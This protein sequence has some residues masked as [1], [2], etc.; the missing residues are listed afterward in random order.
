[1]ALQYPPDWNLEGIGFTVPT[2]AVENLLA[3]LRAP[4]E[5]E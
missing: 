5:I 3:V 2:E 4:I 1:M